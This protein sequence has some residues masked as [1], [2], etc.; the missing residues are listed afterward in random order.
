MKKKVEPT[1]RER[2]EKQLLWAEKAEI[3]YLAVRAAHDLN[4]LFA[5][6]MGQANLTQESKGDRQKER[7]VRTALNVSRKGGELAQ[8]LLH[9]SPGA[10]V[11]KKPGSLKKV[12]EG[13]INLLDGVLFSKGISIEKELKRTPSIRMDVSQMQHL[14]FNLIIN[15][16][17]VLG[18]GGR[19]ELKLEKKASG[20]RLA[21][22]DNG[23]GV[24]LSISRKLF[25]P[26]FSHPRGD[27][28]PQTGIGLAIC[29]DIVQDH[30]GIIKV[31]SRLGQG[32]TFIVNL[33][34][35]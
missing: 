15:A 23:P 33:P 30:G 29:Q 18:K 13:S 1:E 25:E 6:L 12:I 34:V 22:S 17:Q 9:F 8:Q 10:G 19:L 4:N 35:G 27:K 11:K 31:R 26:F 5:L 20:I 28:S 24:P 14:I 3:G 32:T 2:L 7:L 16:T 21:V